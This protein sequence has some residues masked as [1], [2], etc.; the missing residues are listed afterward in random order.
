MR[1][2][3]RHEDAD[4]EML[5]FA[6]LYT[7]LLSTRIHRHIYHI[8][9]DH[10]HYNRGTICHIL[11][12][13]QIY[14]SDPKDFVNK[15]VV[16]LSNCKILHCSH[17]TDLSYTYSESLHI[18]QCPHNRPVLVALTSHFCTHGNLSDQPYYIRQHH[19]HDDNVNRVIYFHRGTI[20]SIPGH[21]HYTIRPCILYHK[22]IFRFLS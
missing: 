8:N 20:R 4:I 1:M 14:S 21:S 5:Q 2:L 12:I 18:H 10:L 3:G 9:Q 13:N 11:Q 15:L 22:N 6:Y 16:Y 19:T 17:K 7:S